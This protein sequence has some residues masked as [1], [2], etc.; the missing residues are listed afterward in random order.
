MADAL[1]FVNIHRYDFM[2]LLRYELM[3]FNRAPRA[4]RVHEGVFINELELRV[5]NREWLWVG[6]GKTGVTDTTE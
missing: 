1:L 5:E 4:R 6:V 3:S 2:R